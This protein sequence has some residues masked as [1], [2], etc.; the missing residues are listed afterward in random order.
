MS[1]G[2]SEAGSFARYDRC[3]GSGLPGAPAV[4]DEASTLLGSLERQRATLAWKCADLDVVGLRATVGVSSVT[5]GG[6]LKHLAFMEDINLTT[7]GFVGNLF[8]DTGPTYFV[9]TMQRATPGI[10]T[11]PSCS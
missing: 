5:L 2:R 6:L 4:G 1:G 11:L 3:R 9:P 7:G 10:L 8:E